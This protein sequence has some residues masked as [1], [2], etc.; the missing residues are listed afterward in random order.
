MSRSNFCRGGPSSERNFKTHVDV[1]LNSLAVKIGCWAFKYL[2]QESSS[3]GIG[4]L[5]RES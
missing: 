3:F 5:G 1:S 4:N 2:L